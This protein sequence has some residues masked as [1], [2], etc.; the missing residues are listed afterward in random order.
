MSVLLNNNVIDTIPDSVSDNNV[1]QKAL[2]I[3]ITEHGTYQIKFRGDD[4]SDGYGM[5]I[6]NVRLY[7]DPDAV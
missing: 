3:T 7:C 2:P 4:D 6:A 1:Y 5:T